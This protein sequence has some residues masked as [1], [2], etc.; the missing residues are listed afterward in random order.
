ME[1]YRIKL[2]KKPEVTDL[3]GEK[4][5]VDFDLGKYYML[6]GAANEIWALLRDGILVSEITEALTLIYDIDEAT[7]LRESLIFLR[8][9]EE[10]SYLHLEALPSD[11]NFI[12]PEATR[13]A[14]M[15]RSDPAPL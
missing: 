11:P 8:Q 3:A 12:D 13:D 14:P 2:I 5:M 6:T 4:V 9:L 7:C 15:R 10:M 1:N